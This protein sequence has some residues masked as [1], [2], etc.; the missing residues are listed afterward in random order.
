M[1]RLQSAVCVWTNSVTAALSQSD[2]GSKVHFSNT[3]AL[4][5]W[6]Q[7]GPPDA[8]VSKPKHWQIS[9]LSLAFLLQNLYENGYVCLSLLGTW[10]GRDSECWNPQTSTILQ[11]RVRRITTV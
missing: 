4:L 6:G 1:G 11:A 7:Q 2:R 9:N 10:S 5:T 3:I 8:C